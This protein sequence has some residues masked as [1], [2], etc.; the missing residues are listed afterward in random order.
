MGKSMRF[1]EHASAVSFMP[2]F[3]SGAVSLM[4][5]NLLRGPVLA[6]L[7]L[8]SLLSTSFALAA[9]PTKVVRKQVILPLPGS[10]NKTLVFNSNSPEVLK[11]EGGIL[12]STYPPAGKSNP[13][14]HLNFPLSGRFDIFSHHIANAQEVSPARTLYL[15]YLVKNASGQPVNVSVLSGASYLSQPDAPFIELPKELDNEN[16][17]VYA[18][19]GDRVAGE[20]LLGRTQNIFPEKFVLAPFETTLLLSKSIPVGDLTPPINGRSSL[21]QVRTSG[22]VYLASLAM[23]APVSEDGKEREPS[24]P[25]WIACLEQAGLASPRDKMP[26]PLEQKSSIVYGRVAGVS[27]GDEWQ[28]VAAGDKNSSARFDIPESGRY[29]SFPI[30]SLRG[31]TLGTGQVQT[32]PLLVRYP[33]TAY[34]ANGNYGVKYC[35]DLP[36]YNASD[37]EQTVDL[38]LEAPLKEDDAKEGLTFFEHPA[39][40]VFFRGTVKISYLDA[41]KGAVE[42]YVHLVLHQG[43]QAGQLDNFVL[44]PGQTRHVRVE[45][46]YPA[47][48]TPPQVLTVHTRAAD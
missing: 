31:G 12:L 47:D 34:D 21:L 44:A 18:G 10:L 16:A 7:M 1:F 5:R 37:R 42:H 6:I 9:V 20:I 19:P 26:T 27:Q 2:Q 46:I 8:V 45:L 23:F 38:W 30:S 28:G 33:D 29:L 35:L 48:C 25:E 24:L 17:S 41:E 32:A 43:E 14:A 39:P 3:S 40:G 11:S 22:P 4:S 36:L 15:A 13:D